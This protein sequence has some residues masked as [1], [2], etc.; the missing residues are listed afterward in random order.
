MSNVDLENV[1]TTENQEIDLQI[2][3]GRH[4]ATTNDQRARVRDLDPK[5]IEPTDQSMIAPNPF[6]Q[7]EYG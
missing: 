3:P 2:I 1:V 7:G 4:S 6:E 5:N